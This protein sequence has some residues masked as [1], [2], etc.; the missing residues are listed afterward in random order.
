MSTPSHV[1][2]VRLLVVGG[3]LAAILA[4]PISALADTTPPPTI[5]P[6]ETSG[7][8]I[9]L[10]G[11]SVIGRVLVTTSVDFTCDPFL[12][13]DP[14]TG[15]EVE[16]TDGS[17]EFGAVTILQASGKTVNFGEGTFYGGAIVCDGTS[18]NHR[19]VGVAAGVVPWKAGTA[20]AGARVF[21]TSP[22]FQTSDYAST[23]A[24]AIKLGK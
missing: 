22:D 13:L 24:L 10:S 19:D 16:R 9:H 3:A 2:H 14:E 4:T 15:T 21:I 12:V 1:R 18:V 6:A 20:V 7:A 17:L 23:G 8:T 5:Y 11:S